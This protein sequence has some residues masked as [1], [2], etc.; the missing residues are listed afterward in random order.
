MGCG[1]G[2]SQTQ[3]SKQELDPRMNAILYGDGGQGGLYSQAAKQF[4]NKTP[5]QSV[6]GFNPLQLGA[7]QNMAQQLM[8]PGFGGA[9]AT[10]QVAAKLLGR[11]G[12]NYTPPQQ[13]A[14]PQLDLNAIF[15][16]YAQPQAQPVGITP[17]AVLPQQV[18][19][20]PQQSALPQVGAPQNA[21]P[22]AK[23]FAQSPFAPRFNNQGR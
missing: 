17:Q 18:Q 10:N 20:M 6:A 14:M 16:K 15:G 5:E 13:Q 19:A 9:D 3:T 8:S 7:M 23:Y 2:G 4:L 11:G 22:F 12:V 1:G 21:S